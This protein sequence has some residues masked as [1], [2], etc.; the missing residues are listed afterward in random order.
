MSVSALDAALLLAK[1][2]EHL[3]SEALTVKARAMAGGIGNGD[4]GNGSDSPLATATGTGLHWDAGEGKRRL[5]EV[6]GRMGG[7]RAPLERLL[8]GG[9]DA[10]YS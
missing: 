4:G 1:D 2:G 5:A 6:M 10:E 7:E 8:L 3:L 9:G